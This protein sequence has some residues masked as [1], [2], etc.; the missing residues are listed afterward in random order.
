MKGSSALNT[1]AKLAASR[2][3]EERGSVHDVHVRECL[4]L[5]WLWSLSSRQRWEL[6]RGDGHRH[7]AAPPFISLHICLSFPSAS[8]SA[9]SL[10]SPWL[11]LV[12]LLAK[13]QS[14]R[15]QTDRQTD[16]WMW[17]AHQ[18]QRYLVTLLRPVKVP[19][20]P[21]PLMSVSIL[22]AAL[23][24]AGARVSPPPTTPPL[25]TWW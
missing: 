1:A 19:L 6:P 24:W 14:K 10:S 21:M 9:S 7:P 2:S 4:L 11:L 8:S 3:T 17:A 5:L 18:R 15:R 22:K 13:Q 25:L 12:L 23:M 20:P 16:G